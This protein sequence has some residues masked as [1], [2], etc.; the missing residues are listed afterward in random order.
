MTAGL[1]G[2]SSALVSTQATASAG[3]NATTLNGYRA[4][5]L[6]KAGSYRSTKVIDNFDSCSY[7]ALQTARVRVPGKGFLMVWGSVGAVRDV[8]TGDPA[9]LAARIKVGSKLATNSVATRLIDQGNL[10]ANIGLSGMAPV[11]KSGVKKVTL[12]GSEC[13]SGMAYIPST[14]IETLFVPFGEV[15][16]V[17][18]PLRLRRPATDGPVASGAGQFAPDAT[19]QPQRQGHPLGWILEIASCRM[20]NTGRATGAPHEGG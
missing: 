10:E 15:K 2:G 5:E 19:P 6:V 4:N 20:L 17:T 1:V 14:S 9:T 11:A 8:G 12:Q 13:T 16:L 3:V 7:V 18:P